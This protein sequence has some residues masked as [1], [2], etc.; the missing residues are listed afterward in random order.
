MDNKRLAADLL[1]RYLNG[2]ASAEETEQV[3]NW[4]RTYDNN[5]LELSRDKKNSIEMRM[6]NKL[7]QHM[8]KQPKSMLLVLKT[9]P[10][11]RIAAAVIIIFFIGLGTWKI[12]ALLKASQH[13]IPQFVYATKA[14]EQKTII[15]NDGSEITLSAA[16]RIT[17]PKKFSTTCREIN[18]TEGEAFFKIA[19]DK[20]RPFT[21]RLPGSL[22]TRVLGTSFKIRAFKALAELKIS[23]NTGKVAV[24]NKNQLF[25][26]LIKGQQITYNKIHQSAIIAPTPIV[27]AKI[28]F[29]KTDLSEVIQQLEYLY[30]IKI[31]LA[32][33]KMV[34]LGCTATFHT[35]Q[36][37]DQ[38][39]DIICS[40][41]NLKFKSTPDH[42]S[43]KIYKK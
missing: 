9:S 26:T 40:L 43:F 6:Q 38:I 36:S 10:F 3:E 23:V 7:Q 30:S 5:N 4:Y 34:H 21:V 24:G 2:S 27:D 42:K 25:G 33:A 39:L 22:Y 12:S 17:Y 35:L 31:E 1:K 18:L 19:H 15:L 20:N 32:S 13:N 8:Q 16:S 29:E 37:P 28:V 41:H 11:I 14:G